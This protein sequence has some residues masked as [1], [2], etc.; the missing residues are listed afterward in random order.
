MGLVTSLMAADVWDSKPFH[1]WTD[2]ELAKVL[3][4]SPW[5]GKGAI[6]YVQNRAGQPPI[7]ETALVTWAS[8]RVMRQALAREAFGVTAAVPGEAAAALASTP[9]LYTITV[10]V[11]GTITSADRALYTSEMQNE[12]FL[13][14]RGKTPIPAT[15]ASGQVLEADGRPVE[16]PTAG[17]EATGSPAFAATP[18]Q[19]GGGGAGGGGGTGG[20]GG[21]GAA[22]GA[23][24]MRGSSRGRGNVGELPATTA[25]LLTFRFPRDPITLDDKEVEFVTK[26]CRDGSASGASVTPAADSVQPQLGFASMS[27]PI[28]AWRSTSPSS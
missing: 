23:P 6:S 7:R 8:A 28:R 19:R 1:T 16:A 21:A 11:A 20:G 2:K 12:T 14:V 18:A 25:S 9:T 3:T 4:D 17:R 5:A 26:L 24:P 10:K 15:Q 13:V 22:R 27:Q